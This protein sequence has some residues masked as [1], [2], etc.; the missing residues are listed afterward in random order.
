MR[1]LLFGSPSS[2]SS[3]STGS[4]SHSND[5]S[6]AEVLPTQPP[7]IA[8]NGAGAAGASKAGQQKPPKRKKGEKSTT[9]QTACVYCEGACQL[10]A[11]C[12]RQLTALAS[13]AGRGSEL[14][15]IRGLIGKSLLVANA[16]CNNR[17]DEV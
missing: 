2:E 11:I 8:V 12:S 3:I 15:H 16:D 14:H 10:A 7:V 9:I 4:A 17:Q 5:G 13:P 6:A 1:T